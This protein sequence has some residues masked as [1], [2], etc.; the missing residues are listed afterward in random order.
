MPST[1]LLAALCC[2]AVTSAQ[3]VKV[4]PS[5]SGFLG[6]QVVL[7][8]QFVDPAASVTVTQVTWVKDPSGAKQNLAVHNPDLGTNYPTNTGGRIHFRDPSLRDATLVIDRLLMS[9]DGIYSCEFATYPEGNQEAATNLT[10]LAT[11]KNTAN[12]VVA[13]AGDSEVPVATCTSAEGKPASSI[14]W[15]GNVPGNA[16]TEHTLNPDGTTTVSSKFQAVPTGPMDGTELRCVV[17]QRTL[18]QPQVIPVTLSVQYPP[19]VTIEGYD[20]N[21]YLEREHA[22]LT[23]NVKANPAAGEYKWYMNGGSIPSSMRMM[24]HQL[25]VDRVSYQVNGTFTCEASNSL[26]RSSGSVDIVVRDAPLQSGSTTGAIV[27]GIIAAIVILTVLVTA[28][29]IFRRQRKNADTSDEE[30]PN[31]KPPPPKVVLT[32]TGK[33]ETVDKMESQ[34][35]NAAYFE[36]SGE[37]GNEMTLLRRYSEPGDDEDLKSPLESDPGDYLEQENPIYNEL[38]YPEPEPEPEHRKSQEFVSKGMYV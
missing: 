38:Q 5:V 36:T 29:L 33:M 32:N 20:D 14:S 2:L 35:L 19:I 17:T 25:T 30:P 6:N 3:H 21:W 13:R 26:G 16:S 8:C 4:E 22:S 31:Y 7:R 28:V 18:G 12:P 11:P 1:G 37:E 9:D 10:V 24:G 23:C 27:G 15:E 34:P